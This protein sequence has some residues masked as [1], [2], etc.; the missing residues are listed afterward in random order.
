MECPYFTA[1][2]LTFSLD[3]FDGVLTFL[4]VDHRGHLYRFHE[5]VTRVFC[6]HHRNLDGERG[7]KSSF[8]PHQQTIVPSEMRTT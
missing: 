8:G 4:R 5:W 1:F 7:N 6:A 3:L 2:L